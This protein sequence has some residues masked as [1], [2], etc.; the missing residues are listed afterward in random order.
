MLREAVAQVVLSTFVVALSGAKGLL[1]VGHSE[2]SATRGVEE[3]AP[4]AVHK[5]EITGLDYAFRVPE[6]V[7][8]GRTTITFVNRGKVRH[9]FNLNLLRPGATPEQVMAA[10]KAGTTTRDFI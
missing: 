2:R 8:A 1:V 9:E 6:H 3:S 7:K 5:L 10:L 4:P